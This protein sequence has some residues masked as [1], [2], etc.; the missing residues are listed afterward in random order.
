MSSSAY[1]SHG[2]AS[3]RRGCR[4]CQKLCQA[5][6]LVLAIQQQPPAKV[7]LQASRW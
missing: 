2:V 6:L 5:G 3:P 7:A 1:L 4:P